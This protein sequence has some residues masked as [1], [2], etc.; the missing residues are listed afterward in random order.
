MKTFL[1]H[2]DSQ[3][4]M[5]LTFRYIEVSN[6][7]IITFLKES[8]MSKWENLTLVWKSEKS[9]HIIIDNHYNIKST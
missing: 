7:H 6:W 2:S 8:N 5:L 1:I 4:K 9:H 3:S